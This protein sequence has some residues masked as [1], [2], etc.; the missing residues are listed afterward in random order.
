[1]SINHLKDIVIT[2]IAATAVLDGGITLGMMLAIQYIIGQLNS[3]LQQLIGFIRSA[4]D[5]S[6]SLQRL[7][8]IHNTSLEEETDSGKIKTIPEGDIILENL[9]FRYTP[10]SDYI[11]NDLNITIPRGKTT[12]IVG[13]SGSGKTTLIKLL[14]GFYK[15][16]LGKLKIGTTSISDIY[17]KIWRN[18]CGVVMQEGYIFS[19]SII[20][21]IA[22]SSDEI[23]YDRVINAVHTANIDDFID[24]LPL[25]Y[26]TKIGDKGNGISQGQKQRLLIARAVYKNPEF[27]FFDEA[28][29][30]LDSN[31]ER[32]IT[33]N[34]NT[35]IENK[36]AIIVAHRLSTVK[37]ADQMYPSEQTIPISVG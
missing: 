32:V 4:Q 36:T 23:I 12:A 18:H 17:Q 33:N 30:A 5:A 1:M 29:N 2:F 20:N 8:E 22:E 19:D 35:F 28:T 24:S 9:S 11:L 13:S 37:N 3:P 7:S 26:N 27:M 34:L 21:N 6:I 10:I 15:P 14:L 25:G 31:N 16:E